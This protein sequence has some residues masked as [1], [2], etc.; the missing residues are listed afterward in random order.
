[1]ADHKNKR[2]L[3]S[4]VDD[5]DD[6]EKSL[7]HVVDSA[8]D[9]TLNRLLIDADSKREP[10]IEDID[11]YV[12][13][14]NLVQDIDEVTTPELEALERIDPVVDFETSEPHPESE[15]ATGQDLEKS[16]GLAIHAAE[17]Q[18]AAS[19]DDPELVIFDTSALEAQC[20]HL[21]VALETLTEQ[22][23][24][25]ARELHDKTDKVS[26][27]NTLKEIEQLR[28]QIDKQQRHLQSL[29]SSSQPQTWLTLANGLAGAAVLL[30]LIFGWQAFSASS[31]VETLQQQL[32]QQQQ[33]LAQLPNS[34]ALSLA[35]REQLDSLLQTTQ[36][37]GAQI[38]DLAKNHGGSTKSNDDLG[39]QLSKLSTQSK[40]LD[41]AVDA[42]QA[43][44]ASLE[45]SKP[46]SVQPAKTDKAVES[47]KADRADLAGSGWTVTL[48]G[49]KHDWYAARKAEEYAAKGF[50]V[51]VAR[52]TQKGEPWFRLVAD[53]FKSQQEADAFAARAR[54]VLNLDS[55]SVGR[56]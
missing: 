17:Q 22:Q 52:G 1:M 51:K 10:V 55:V 14:D 29:A 24:V 56:N 15:V 28:V 3:D 5:L 44:V 35:M 36:T 50:P 31:E 26:F 33:Q 18:Q 54:K 40:Q 37:L 21:Q 25:L 45:K 16:T 39:R 32:A 11:L 13:E 53:G 46:A 23:H 30:T 9:D 49:S 7:Q 42:L 19:Q 38:T 41:D 4:F 12:N 20:E 6:L 34:E 27:F 47:K 43:R 8:D 48:T 2:N